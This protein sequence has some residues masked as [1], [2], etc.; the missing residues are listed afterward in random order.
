MRILICD[1]DL[2]MIEKLIKLI[3]RYFSNVHLKCHEIAAFT[4]GKD[5]LNDEER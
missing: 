3:R 5:V 4:N 1:D 2:L